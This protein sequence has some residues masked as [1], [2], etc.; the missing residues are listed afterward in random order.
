MARTTTSAVA[1]P[2]EMDMHVAKPCKNDMH[3]TARPRLSDRNAILP[4][5]LTARITASDELRIVSLR[6]P[7]VTHRARG[8]VFFIRRRRIIDIQLSRQSR[9]AR[10]SL[11]I[12]RADSP[13]HRFP[14]GSIGLRDRRRSRELDGLDLTVG[15]RFGFE[16]AAGVFG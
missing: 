11:R 10:R 6:V 16:A 3:V 8:I 7:S 2:C 5:T 12:R 9:R 13:E 1:K 15:G 4:S 14:L